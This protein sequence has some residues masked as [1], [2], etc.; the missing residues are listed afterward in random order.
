M[1]PC[2]LFLVLAWAAGCAPALT[3]EE[4]TLA[5]LAA[6]HAP[7]VEASGFWAW[8]GHD[9]VVDMHISPADGGG[10]FAVT[11]R[12]QEETPL[13]RTIGTLDDGVLTLELPV[14]GSHR[15]HFCRFDA[16][17]L[18]VSETR[19]SFTDEGHPIPSGLVFSKPRVAE[20]PKNPAR[21]RRLEVPFSG[22]DDES[23]DVRFGEE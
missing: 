13:E 23:I 9:G 19:V 11:F 18:L 4:R 6:H 1:N 16:A 3:P 20:R 12:T 8:A 7:D 10:R 21:E 5:I 15:F 2:S 22:P 14:L 17:D